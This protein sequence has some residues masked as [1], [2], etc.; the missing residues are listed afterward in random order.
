M[1]TPLGAITRA[2]FARRESVCVPRWR[3]LGQFAVVYLHEGAG[4]YE[5]TNGLR[6]ALIPGDLIVLFPDLAH[7]YRPAS[8]TV[9]G[10][11]HLCFHGPASDVWQIQG[12]LKPA[13]PIYH[14]EPVADWSRRFEAVL[15]SPRSA[16]YAPPLYDICRL[17][18]LL[19]EI[20]TGAGHAAQYDADLRWVSRAC[21]LIEA[22]L[23]GPPNWEAIARPLGVTADGFRKRFARLAH[24]PP[25]RYRMSRLI[26]RAC[27]LMAADI[28]N[29]RQIAD[30]LGFCDAQY[31]SRRFKE[32]TGKAP[33][34]F[35]AGI[36]R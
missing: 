33:R 15:S 26:D 10:S 3:T 1:A 35:R 8:G 30:S 19:A 34:T 14:L 27:E 23:G 32:I 5:D 18:Q 12:L 7:R 21:S 9:W 36:S 16:G 20:V 28:M 4:I 24:Q 17:Q 2:G 25:A 6:R 22:E 29:D 11:T 31:F 13:A